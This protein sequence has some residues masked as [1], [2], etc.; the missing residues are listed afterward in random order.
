MYYFINYVRQVP[1]VYFGYTYMS[2][3]LIK[4][5]FSIKLLQYIMICTMAT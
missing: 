5:N 4:Q 3:I 1:K 2:E